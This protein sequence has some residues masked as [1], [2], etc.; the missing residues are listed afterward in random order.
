MS[1]RRRQKGSG[2]MNKA[3]RDKII[4]DN[5]GLVGMIVKKYTK[6]INRCSHIDLEDLVNV[7]AIGLIKACDR[8]DLEYGAKFSTFAVP[9]IWG[10]IKRF[11]RDNADTIYFTRQ[12]KLDY[13]KIVEFDL[14]NETPEEISKRLDIPTSRAKE[15]L[16]Y[17]RSQNVDSLDRAILDDDGKSS[18][19]LAD[20]IGTEIDM[21]FSLEVELFLNSLDE[22]TRKIIKLRLQD[23]KQSEIGEIMGVSQVTISRALRRVKKQ[24]TERGIA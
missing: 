7:G 3:E 11:M 13:Y 6:A 2:K 21:D 14:I 8:F 5:M 4:L 22:R 10:T 19:T 15:A 12:V 16:A 9:Y 17:Y 20:T 18:I 24:L 23:L 1:W